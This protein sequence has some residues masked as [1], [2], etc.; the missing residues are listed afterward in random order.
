MA[1]KAFCSTLVP[2]FQGEEI[3]VAV[4]NL[5]VLDNNNDIVLVNGNPI[6]SVQ[7]TLSYSSTLN[8]LQSEIVSAIRDAHSDQTITVIFLDNIGL[9]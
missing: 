5:V 6:L 2:N 7:V 1:K 8:S 3:V 9:L 4:D